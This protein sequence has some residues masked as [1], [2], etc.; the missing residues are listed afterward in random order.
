MTEYRALLGE[1][2]VPRLVGSAGHA[3]IRDTLKRELAR[4]GFAVTEHRFTASPVS[5][6]VVG[7]GGLLLAGL[8]LF[9]VIESASG[10][11]LLV[12][13]A[14]VIGTGA[15]LL[16][17][18][19]PLRRVLVAHMG[20]RG[21]EALTLV[22]TRPSSPIAVWLVAHSDAKGQPISMA[23]RLY[24]VALVAVAVVALGAL[25]VGHFA[26][27]PAGP[28]AWIAASALALLGGGLLA[29]NAWIRDSPG[30]VD[31]ATGVLAVLATVDRLPRDAPVGVILPD[32][33]EFG[34]V[35]ATALVKARPA[36]LRDT[37]VINFDGIDDR[38][39]TIA[40]VH[41][42]GSVVD[43][44]VAALGARRF[45]ALPVFVDGLILARVAREC[46]TILK[47][48]WETARIVHTKRD[49]A[50][51]LTLEGVTKVAERV[52]GVVARARQR[53]TGNGKRDT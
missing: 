19:T 34:L 23:T 21:T 4:R 51:R 2:A 10:N 20:T 52:A 28:R 16:F 24:A 43:A 25:T 5:L 22:A 31:N 9:G 33:E 11:P 49:T 45:R 37:A 47:G 27:V 40:F 36:L 14:V 1:L 17:A 6:A 38:G 15:L 26:G 3:R 39:R 42:P 50:E 18:G 8:G 30:A 46:V 29:M 12:A 44:V 41:R 13:Q 48:N 53:E 32:A 35:G 7:C